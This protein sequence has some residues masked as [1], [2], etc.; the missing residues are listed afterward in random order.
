MYEDYEKKMERKEQEKARVE[1]DTPY[2]S[3]SDH[4]SSHHLDEEIN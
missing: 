1:D 2:A 3:S 4:S